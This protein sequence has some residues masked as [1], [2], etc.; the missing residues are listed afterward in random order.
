VGEPDLSTHIIPLYLKCYDCPAKLKHLALSMV[1]KMA[2]RIDG[3]FLKTRL[4]PKLLQLLKD[5]ALEIRKDSLKALYSILGVVDTQTLS[6]TILPGLEIARKAGSDPFVNA[7]IARMYKTLG[8]T[9]QIDVVSSKI[10]P[11][12]IPYLTDPSITKT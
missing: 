8:E 2:K 7:I 3:Q 5:P 6:L 11:T 4:L 10:L 12:L 9:L 1:E